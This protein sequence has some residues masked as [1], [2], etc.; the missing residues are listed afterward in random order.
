LRCA[1]F[2]THLATQQ[3][4]PILIDP[5]WQEI[6]FGDW[7]GRTR[8]SIWESNR[9]Q[10]LALWATPIEFCAPGGESMMNF[11]SRIKAAF[12]QLLIDH[13]G[14]SILLITHAGAIRAILSHALGIDYHTTQKFN[15]EHAKLNRVRLYDDGEVSLLNWACSASELE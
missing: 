10:L 14:K 11:V 8:Q 4:T 15:V 5:H 9:S 2:A 3:S 12:E 13:N 6:D 1:E 7:I